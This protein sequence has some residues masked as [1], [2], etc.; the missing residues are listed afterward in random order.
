MELLPSPSFP[1]ESLPSLSP[2]TAVLLAHQLA[3]IHQ[4]AQLP[5]L[6]GPSQQGPGQPGGVLLGYVGLAA[7]R[8][9]GGRR[10]GDGDH[11]VAAEDVSFWRR[12]AQRQR[13]AILHGGAGR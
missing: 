10:Q 4:L 6:Q 3:K 9:H 11:A 8:G 12:P 13:L 2:I 1:P 5:S 7:G